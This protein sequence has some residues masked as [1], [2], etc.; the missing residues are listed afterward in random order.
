MDSETL[1]NVQDGTQ[2]IRN[3]RAGSDCRIGI[4]VNLYDCE[5]GDRTMI[6]P[7]I[8]IQRG[9]KIG[10]RCK[11]QSH[12]FICEGI[13]IE[14]EV[15]V[16]HGV[17]FTNDRHPRSTNEQG[18]PLTDGEWK[19]EK[20]IVRKGASIGSGAVILPGI[21]I[22]E[23]AVVGAGAV[24]V[25]SVPAHATVVG[26]PAKMIKK[27]E[28]SSKNTKSMS[29]PFIDLKRDIAAHK[30]EYL[31]IAERIMDSC[32]FTLGPEVE[33]FE[34]AFAG[35]LGAKHVIG[36]ANGTLALYAAL[37]ALGIGRDDEVIVPAN[38]FVATAE[39]VWMVGA[40]PVFIDIDPKTHLMDLTQLDRVATP[41]T[42]AVIAVHLYGNMVDV[43]A[44]C[45]WTSPRSIRIIEDAAQAH[46]AFWEDGQ[47]VGTKGDIG[48]FSFYPTKCLGA[49][50]EAGGIA[51]NDD[52]LA[53]AMR[54]IRFHGSGA[55]KYI[56]EALATNL[57]MNA[58][59]AA[60]LRSKLAR[61]EASIHRRR[62]I[63]EMYRSAFAD[64]PL[65]LPP[66]ASSRHAFYVYTVATDERDR[67]QEHL[68]SRGI[69]CGVY[70]PI[71]IHEQP[72]YRSY[73][74]DDDACPQASRDAKRIL[75]IPMFADLTD[76]EIRE[77]IR[78]VRETF[79]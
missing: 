24:V 65:E 79:E 45:A 55:Q 72:A 27:D 75:S 77:V 2:C 3:V 63:A 71:P 37:L 17:I 78:A 64:L 69:G 40:K 9:V 15:F 67:L 38:T 54:L 25:E 4:F 32:G 1:M 16:G 50:G 14:D 48:C 21:E 62:E 11:V 22:G 70:Y 13:T 36:V 39:A 53:N 58:F 7:F 66:A 5:I 56:H 20:T 52:E 57:K 46:G 43:D 61:F 33:Q 44:L 30:E 28:C 42:K 68:Q 74:G 73:V 10:S 76:E 19:L 41:K 60:I 18:E 31:S 23:G 59:Q 12:S 8:E 35:Y 49:F 26:V 47:A 6:G 29:V 51:T 34:Q